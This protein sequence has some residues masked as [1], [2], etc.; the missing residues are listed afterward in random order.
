MVCFASCGSDSSNSSN[1]AANDLKIFKYN[2]PSALY[3]LDP[4]FAKDQASIWIAKQLFNT[5]VEVD[6]NLNL[7]PSLATKWDVSE[8]G[9]SYTFYLRDDVFFSNKE[10]ATAEKLTAKDVVFS[11]ERLINPKTASPGA[12]VFNGRVDE[13]KPFVAVD[14]FTFQLNLKSAFQPIMG[15]LSMQYCSI[16]SEKAVKQFGLDFRKNPVGSGAFSL[17]IWKEGETLILEK[18]KNYWE[19]DKSGTSLPYLDGVRVSFNE[20]KRSAFL[21]FTEG[22]THFLSGIDA[23]Y[24][25]DLLTEIGEL[26]EE[27]GDRIEMTKTPYLNSEYLGF[28]MSDGGS[29]VLK[30]KRVR[31]AINYGFDRRKMVQFLRNNIGKPAEQGFIPPGLPAYNPNQKGYTFNREK[32]SKLLKEA[33]YSQKNPMPEITLATTSSYK[34]I[35]VFMQQQLNDLGFNIKLELMP[36]SFL[37][38]KMSKGDTQFFRASWI[39]DYPDAETFLTVFY[40]GNPAPPNYTNFKNKNFD[41]LYEQALQTNDIEKRILLYQKMDSIL[42]EEAPI[43]PLFYDE[44]VRFQQKNIFGMKINAFNLLDLKTVKLP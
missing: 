13:E 32:A 1:N 15:I 38:E 5:L 25:D 8:D 34:D 37:R 33:G 20:N 29:N 3:S 24:K 36:P 19:K 14:D 31:Q 10:G 26:K 42:I 27:W 23:S 39:A 6:E 35:C 16:V 12:W 18:N 22:E 2:Q 21:D 44:V 17:K 30:D 41:T 40:G 4:A 28:L 11:F 7:K 43:V 9:L